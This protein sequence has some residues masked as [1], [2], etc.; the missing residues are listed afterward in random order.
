MGSLA[1]TI[2]MVKQ[3][4]DFRVANHG[5]RAA[6]IAN[7]ETPGYK[8]QIP[9]F[10]ARLDSKMSEKPNDM[11]RPNR[12]YDF[13]MRIDASRMTPREDGNNVNVESEMAAMA[14]NSLLYQT[15]LKILNKELAL[16]RYAITAG[17]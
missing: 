16:T 11:M 17:R 3:Y 14:E 7:A 4:L 10:E 8:S 9:S 2:D 13:E 5:I 6:N 12:K 1:N 15:G